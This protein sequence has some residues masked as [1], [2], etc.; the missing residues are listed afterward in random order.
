MSRT[1]KDIKGRTKKRLRDLKS[2][3]AKSFKVKAKYKTIN[4]KEI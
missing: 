4:E 2:Y 3:K 1:K